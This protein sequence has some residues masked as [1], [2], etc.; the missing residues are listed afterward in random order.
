MARGN[1][2]TL[3]WRVLSMN[4]GFCNMYLSLCGVIFEP[5]S[6]KNHKKQNPLFFEPIRPGLSRVTH[7]EKLPEQLVV[8]PVVSVQEW[9]TAQLTRKSENRTGMTPARSPGRQALFHGFLRL[10]CD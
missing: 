4:C 7:F 5:L 3:K 2:S 10:Q 8:K 1:I 9:G 6:N